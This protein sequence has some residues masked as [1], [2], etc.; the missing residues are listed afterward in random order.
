MSEMKL[1]NPNKG[2]RAKSPQRQ[3]ALRAAILWIFHF[4]GGSIRTRLAISFLLLVVIPL[5]ASAL[6]S[7]IVLRR[8]ATTDVYRHL[9]S[10]SALKENSV[11]A[12]VQSM[13]DTLSLLYHTHDE[14]AL[15]EALISEAITGETLVNT[16]NDLNVIFSQNK[17]FQDLFILDLYGRVIASTNDN[18][19]GKVYE[20]QE[21]FRKGQAKIFI[22]PPQY[23]QSLREIVVIA[24]KPLR[25]KDGKVGGVLAGR[26][27]LAALNA[28][29]MEDIG[30]GQ[31]GESYLVRTNNTLLTNSKFDGYP[32]GETYIRTVGVETVLDEFKSGTASYTGYRGTQVLGAYRWLP[33]IQLV[34][35]SEV[36]QNEALYST[37]TST[38]INAGVAVVAAL[39]AMLVAYFVTRTIADPISELV[40]VAG[41]L[42]DG[43][44]NVKI[45]M[46]R[47]G[48]IGVL[49]F[50]FSNMA[51]QLTDLIA[52]LE[53]RVAARTRDLA[54]VAEV[55]TATATILESKQLLQ[56]VVDLTKE[57]FNLYH[58]HIYLLD[59]D[60]KNLILAA[61]AG[62][63][64]R[65]MTMKGH[66]IPL[67]RE[68]SLV[69][70]AA[71]EQKGVTVNDVTQAPDF[72][73]NPLLPDTRSEL[74]VPMVVGGNLIGV[75]DI[76][77]D[78]VERFT[79]T[80][81]NIQTTLA[82]QLA[83]SIQNVRSF[84]QS[85]KQ[86]EFESTVNTIG[87]KIQQAETIEETLK[88]GIR[89][90][91]LALGA[92]QVSAS[93]SR[94]EDINLTGNN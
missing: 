71:R 53:S 75:F 33:D 74:A 11:N 49:A 84:E 72:L 68:Q 4:W 83:T 46:D 2:N 59:D 42:A 38:A 21:F 70:R 10:A 45:E 27:D 25:T 67:D 91:G 66:S 87:Q 37:F 44:L 73:P 16:Q 13:E 63:P 34:L 90:I 12:W 30:I 65:I 94:H 14:N 28:I 57:R 81:V 64:G 82:A 78:Q 7:T 93:I 62:E 6:I 85:R 39:L 60:K 8:A 41:Q 24:S 19:I 77:S 48:E 32:A 22:Q 76:Q 86:A 51:K 15:A 79:E 56:E 3:G 52:N 92:P 43:N 69:A 1:E 89:E 17:V 36:D 29:M 35:V 47:K 40:N 58:S 26:A 31:S 18:D 23:S 80:D 50:A 61:G 54:I 88:I 55:G 9:S 20:N 5:A